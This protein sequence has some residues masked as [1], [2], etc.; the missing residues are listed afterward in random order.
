MS[1]QPEEEKLE[2][3]DYATI[4]FLGA[5]F[6]TTT[7]MISE[8]SRITLGIPQ[9]FSP[10]S[11]KKIL[12]TSLLNGGTITLIMLEEDNLAIIQRT[13]QKIGDLLRENKII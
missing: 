4:F 3:K 8:L 13:K 10:I 2:L 12:K 5:L 6:G 9:C 1:H 7:L 11:F